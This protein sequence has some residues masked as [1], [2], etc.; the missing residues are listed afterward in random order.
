MT[1]TNRIEYKRELSDGLEKEVIAFLNYREGGIIHIG[2]DKDG[3]TYGLADADGDQLKIKDRLKNNIRPSALGLFDIVSEERDAKNILKII[4]ASGPE[5]P[6]YLKKYGMSEKGCFIRLGSAAE[7]MPQKM[8]DELF[9]KRTRNS[10]SKIK[11]GRQD[12]SFSQL[13]I[14]YEESGHTLGKAFA[15]NLELLTEDGAFNYA[16]Y[17]LADKN[18]TS[19]KVAKYSGKTRT[20]LIESNEYGHECLVKAT[21][22]VIDKIAVENRTNTKI[23]AKERQ[24]ANL[25][26]SIAL[27][28]AII[29]AFVH[30][31]YTNEIT[32]KFEIFSD[33]IEIT[34]AGSLP[35]GLSEQEFYEG[36]SVPRNK[37]LMRIFKDLELVEQL[38]SGI[39]RILEH[40][41]KE[42]FKFSDNFLRMTFTAKETAVEEGGQIGGVMGGLKGGQIG[43]QKDAEIDDIKELTHRQKEVLKLIASDNRI[44]RSGIAEILHIN[45]SAIQ[46]H[47]N[48]L[49]DAGFIERVGGTR[50]Y[51]EV[52]L[53]K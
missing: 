43:G 45:E 31:D 53:S 30:N 13:K 19:I 7:P 41:G 35:E 24:Q 8:I 5:K 42:S 9:A 23:T 26:N 11:A 29:N 1:E 51:W 18:N 14:Y 17:L 25:W 38:G 4:V 22:Q 52:K 10:I 47:L 46:K 33:R 49:K 40:Y 44:S 28:E 15:K 32:P 20:D 39:P 48:N 12:L 27:R 36:F 37:E 16:G 6:Y 3:N 2:I 34:S 21:K 50:G